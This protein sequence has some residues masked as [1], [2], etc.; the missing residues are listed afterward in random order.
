VAPITISPHDPDVIYHGSQYVHRTRDEGKTWETISPDLTA[1]RP[2]RQMPSGGPITR[3]ITGEEHYSTLYVIEE[4]PV[5]QGVIWT[6]AN[7]GPVFVTTDDG[8]TWTNVTPPDMPPE[9]RIQNIEPSPHAAGKAYVAGYRYLLGDFRPYIYRTEDFGASWTLLT[10]GANGIAD[11]VPTRVV[12]E[13]PGREGLLFAGTEFGMYLS[14]DDGGHWQHFQQN[15]PVTPVT[16][17]KIVDGDLVLSTMGRSFWIMDDIRPLEEL[18]EFVASEEFY[19]F[20]SGDA[21]RM[22]TAGGGGSSDSMPEYA[23]S[24][25]RLDYYLGSAAQ[26][27]MRLEILN[28]GGNV[29]RTV[30]GE[31]T[32]AENDRQNPGMRGP[33]FGGRGAGGLS[34]E[35]GMHR[36]VW[37]LRVDGPEGENGRPARGPLVVPGTYTARL[38]IGDRSEEHAFRVQIDPRVAADGV[39]EDDMRAQFDLNMRVLELQG[40][41]GRTVSRIEAA[42]E[43][44]AGEEE[45]RAEDADE[46]LSGLDRLYDRLVTDN[47]D[48]YPPPMIVSQLGYLRGMI[49]SAD[50]VPGA[51]AYTRYDEL[52]AELSEVISEVDRM[53]SGIDIELP[54]R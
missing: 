6:G 50:Q 25:A 41:A 2:E 5:R 39:T 35:A 19:F 43:A 26:G 3:D 14:F 47:S 37:D 48:S 10:D 44:L 9:G 22:R 45:N 38:T 54:S 51:D 33:F 24:G 36:F 8:G 4:S 31:R 40:A 13:D 7:D 20:A 29:I 32:Q 49:S 52:N 28:E 30:G 12:R 27:S 46:L 16:D 53:L 34:P 15:L 23:S 1:F 21:F 17:I 18:N 11:N 42:R